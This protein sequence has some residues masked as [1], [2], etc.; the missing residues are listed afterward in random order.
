[1]LGRGIGKA[2]L[3]MR[4]QAASPMVRAR[5][6]PP[7]KQP[8]S[9]TPALPGIGVRSPA[10]GAH[11][12]PRDGPSD[13]ATHSDRD[14]VEEEAR[15]RWDGGERT[16]GPCCDSVRGGREKATHGPTAPGHLRERPSGWRPGRSRP[17]AKS[18]KTTVG[19]ASLATSPSASAARA[20]GSPGS[21][22]GDGKPRC[23]RE[24]GEGSPRGCWRKGSHSSSTGVAA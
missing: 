6:S 14:R 23:S 15:R 18:S 13:R 20:G 11:S 5:Q 10:A 4:R 12:V 2:A 24:P 22:L 3:M 17:G 8:I 1:M 16:G 21:D 19:A 7:G 9:E